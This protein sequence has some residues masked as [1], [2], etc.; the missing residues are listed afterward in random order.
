[1]F[2]LSTVYSLEVQCN[3]MSHV[4]PLPQQIK[5]NEMGGTC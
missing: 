4:P 5:E 2:L 1:M 3:G